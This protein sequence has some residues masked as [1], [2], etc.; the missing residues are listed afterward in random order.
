V[1]YGVFTAEEAD[2]VAV[3]GSGDT[4]TVDTI[5]EAA[6]SMSLKPACFTDEAIF[7]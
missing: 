4:T 2:G 1:F 5:L 6:L 3:K 7:W